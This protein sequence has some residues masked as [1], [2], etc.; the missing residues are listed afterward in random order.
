MI[1]AA[2][3]V[4]AGTT[5]VA[6]RRCRCWWC[7]CRWAWPCWSAPRCWSAA[8]QFLAPLLT[9]RTAA[10]QEDVART[11][12]M[13]TDLVQGVRA[14]RGIGAEDAATERYRRT[15]RTA[16]ASTLHA[17][18]AVGVYRG[19]TTLGSGLF[20]T[21]VAGFAGALAF[22]GELSVGDLVTVVGLAQFLA[23]PIGLLGFAGQKYAEAKASAARIADVLGAAG[24]DRR[25]APAGPRPA[26]AG[27]S[28]ARSPPARWPGCP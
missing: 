20:L 12:G 17:A 8:L 28:C 5:A 24:A 22:D 10:Q 15:S 21:G 26:R 3:L 25:T 4:V 9:R 2:S 27:W 13:A 7:T 18:R 23:E 11:A 14:L 16:L 6:S 1:E 19:V